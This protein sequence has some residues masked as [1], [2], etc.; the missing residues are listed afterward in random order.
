[1]ETPNET[2]RTRINHEL[3]QLAREYRKKNQTELATSVGVTQAAISKLEAGITEE[4][5]RTLLESLAEELQFPVSFFLQEG[6]AVTSIGSSA[7]YNRGRKKI[8][9]GQMKWAE[10]KINLLRSQIRAL[11]SGVSINT[12]RSIPDLDIEEERSAAS[13][14]RKLRAFWNIPSGPIANLTG[15]IESTGTMV[16]P[17]DFGTKHLD[18]TCLWLANC[19]PLIFVNENLPADRYRW[20]IAH[21]LGHLV[22]HHEPRETQESEADDFAAELLMPSGDIRPYFRRKLSLQIYAELKPVWK[23]SMAALVRRTK[24]LRLMSERQYR[25]Y[26]M[27]LRKLGLPEPHQFEKEKPKAW[28]DLIRYH[29]ETLGRSSEDL[30]KTMH[31]PMDVLKLHTELLEDGPRLRIVN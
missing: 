29:T 15:L 26:N 13:A 18:G 12:K 27:N 31:A 21:E 10:A 5:S 2:K 1:M 17:C 23:V 24:D 20:T 28:A 7:L 9:I 6:E 3:L 22:M 11:L 4:V 16:L 8:T 14:A 19:P 30:V 25:Y